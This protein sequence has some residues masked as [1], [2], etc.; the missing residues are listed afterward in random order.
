[1]NGSDSNTSGADVATIDFA[2]KSGSDMLSNDQ[3]G[4][5][6][7]RLQITFERQQTGSVLFQPVAP[8]DHTKGWVQTD[9]LT[10]LPVSKVKIW[11]EESGGWVLQDTSDPVYVPPPKRYAS[12]TAEAGASLVTV[13]FED[14]K[15]SEYFVVVTPVTLENGT[16]NPA[17]AAFPDGYGWAITNKTNTSFSIQFRGM[18]AAGLSFEF[19]IT[20]KQLTA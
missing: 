4:E 13:S 9:I 10:G 17:P 5:I 15:T 12:V 18:P 8:D 14:I 7:R 19:E 3:L 11:D 16:W 2:E 20:D 6:A 1:M